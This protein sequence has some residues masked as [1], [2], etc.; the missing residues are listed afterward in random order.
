MSRGPGFCEA[1]RSRSTLAKKAAVVGRTGSG[2]TSVFAAA[3][4]LYPLAGGVVRLDGVDLAALPLAIARGVIRAVP[5]DAVLISGSLRENLIGDDVADE[6]ALVRALG[7]VGL[8]HFASRLDSPVGQELLSAGEKQMVGLA[9]SLLPRHGIYP[10]VILADEATSNVDLE[11]DAKAHQVL[12]GLKAT[13][14]MICHR[15]HNLAGFDD[16]VV[17]DRGVVAEVGPPAKLLADSESRLAA[18][19]HRAGLQCTVPE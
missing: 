5:Q 4:R 11:T 12:F 7:A 19:V 6:Q 2:K 16:V 10:R 17:L 3:S 14:V 1:Y 9:R 13:L 15:L 8:A 18:L